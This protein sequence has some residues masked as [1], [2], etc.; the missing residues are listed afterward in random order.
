[1]SVITEII[2]WLTLA[3]CLT[4]WWWPTRPVEG[5]AALQVEIYADGDLVQR[6]VTAEGRSALKARLKETQ[7]AAKK[8]GAINIKQHLIR[9]GKACPCGSGVEAKDCCLGRYRSMTTKAGYVPAP[10][11]GE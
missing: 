5:V 7:S 9:P 6:V 8:A 1:M 11:E 3:I 2:P 10:V 4:I